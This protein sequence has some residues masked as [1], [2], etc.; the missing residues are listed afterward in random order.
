MQ[1]W[2]TEKKIYRPVL[3]CVISD[4]EETVSLLLSVGVSVNGYL[5]R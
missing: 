2:N 3:M 5:F 1:G 4:A